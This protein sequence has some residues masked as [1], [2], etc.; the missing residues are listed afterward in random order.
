MR[1]R[2]YRLL[3][4]LIMALPLLVGVAWLV[5]GHEIFTKSGKYESVAM[6]DPLFGDSI[7]QKQWVP[8]PLA[9]CYIGLDLVAVSVAI[10][11]IGLLLLWWLNRRYS[12]PEGVRH[13]TT[14]APA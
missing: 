7:V 8:G 4:L 9:G 11:I 14:T 1:A 12:R 5:S 10:A 6:K 13:D 2:S 3:R